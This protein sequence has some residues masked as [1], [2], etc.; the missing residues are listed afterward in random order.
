MSPQYDVRLEIVPK[1]GILDPQANTLNRSKEAIL[2]QIFNDRAGEISVNFLAVGRI[3]SFCID[4]PDMV[5]A[6][7]Q[8]AEMIPVDQITNPVIQRVID[9]S[10]TERD[11]FEVKK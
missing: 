11:P 9:V 8:V 6:V 7:K 2:D 5:A 1:K 4:C 10:I 3:L